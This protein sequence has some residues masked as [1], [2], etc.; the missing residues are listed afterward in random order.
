MTAVFHCEI[1]ENCTFL[2]YYSAS[3]ITQK[4]AVLTFL[5]FITFPQKIIKCG[6]MVGKIQ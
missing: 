1:D 6:N 4:S 3:V 2:G 5:N